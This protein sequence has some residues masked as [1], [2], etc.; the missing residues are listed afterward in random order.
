MCF[1]Y[2][3]FDTFPIYVIVEP[4]CFWDNK[5]A[6][7]VNMSENA[8]LFVYI[9]GPAIRW[10]LFQGVAGPDWHKID[11]TYTFSVAQT[12][13]VYLT[14]ISIRAGYLDKHIWN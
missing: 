11:D 13:V 10:Q 3:K 1:H 8:R 14:I 5:P 2:R 9:Y 6:L 4:G 7:V 12:S